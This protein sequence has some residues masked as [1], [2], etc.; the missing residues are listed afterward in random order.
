MEKEIAIMETG[1]LKKDHKLYEILNSN[2]A[3]KWWPI[4]KKDKDIYI[5]V[6]KM[7]IIDIYYL[8]G[9]MAEIKYDRQLKNITA[10]AHPKYLGHT[11]T[12]DKKYYREHKGKNKIEYIPIYQDCKDWLNERLDEMKKNIRNFYSGEA[13]GENT[14]EKFIQGKLI[15]EGRDKYIDSEFAHRLFDKERN[16]IRIDLVKIENEKFVFEELK[17]IG[18][19]RLRTK[20]GKPEILTQI[21][22]YRIFLQKN[23]DKLSEYYRLLY[24]IKK[25]LGL[26]IP[27]VNDITKIN[28]DI[29]PQLLIADIYEKPKLKRSENARKE[30]IDAI[31]KILETKNIIPTYIKA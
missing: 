8:G 31:N 11:D 30:R 28:V 5:E 7:N 12:K 20:D 29:E 27:N 4:L 22:N 18:D 14:S 2:K 21:E 26:P 3:P 19:N 1:L 13:N 15:I 6:R 9:R 24:N 16:T 25:N 10:T 17:R 23:K